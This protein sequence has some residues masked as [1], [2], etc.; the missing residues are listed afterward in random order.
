[1]AIAHLPFFLFF[2]YFR[3][4]NVKLLL[5]A[6][7]ESICYIRYPGIHRRQDEP[8]PQHDSVKSGSY[9]K[10]NRKWTKGDV[11]DAAHTDDGWLL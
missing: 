6:A 7:A 5:E 2:Q 4:S 11:V 8:Q 10:I 1:M 3:R 9:L